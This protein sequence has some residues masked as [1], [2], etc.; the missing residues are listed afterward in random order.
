M[1]AHLHAGSSSDHMH[2]SREVRGRHTLLHSWRMLLKL[3]R[4]QNLNHHTSNCC[5]HTI[6]SICFTCIG[7]WQMVGWYMVGSYRGFFFQK[8]CWF[9]KWFRVVRGPG[10]GP[11]GPIWAHRGPYGPFWAHKPLMGPNGPCMNRPSVDLPCSSTRYVL[12]EFS[13]FHKQ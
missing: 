1:C 4:P 13:N 2:K 3:S 5:G 6:T 11:Y 7:C 9:L 10:P 8:K 12:L